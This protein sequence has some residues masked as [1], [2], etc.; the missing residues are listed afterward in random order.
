M[1]TIFLCLLLSWSVS[2]SAQTTNQLSRF[3]ITWQFD[4]NVE[5]GQFVNGDYYVVAPVT[6]TNMLPAWTG[7]DNGWEVN[8]Q[9]QL[10]Q[11]FKA[12][13]A[14]YNA[15]RRPELPFTISTNASLVKVIGGV[16]NSSY[17]ATA[18]VLTILT[19]APDNN[20]A[21]SFRPPYIGSEKPIYNVSQLKTN[22]LPTVPIV[23][24]AKTLASV[25]V[26]FSKCLRMDHHAIAPRYFRPYT[27]LV[28]YMPKNT[29]PLNESMLRLIGEGTIEDKM[30]ALILF[31]Q[32]AIDRAYIMRQG[33]GFA[34]GTGENPNQQIIAAWGAVMLGMTNYLEHYQTT[35]I[36]VYEDAMISRN[37]SD[38]VL[39]GEQPSSSWENFYWTYIRTGSGNKKIRDPYGFIDGGIPGG[40]G[41]Q[42]IVSQPFKAQ[43]LLLTLFPEL[44]TGFR[45]ETVTNILDYSRRWVTNGYWSLPDPVAPY[46]GISTNYTITYGPDGMGGYIA[47]PSRYPT[48]HG[49]TPDGGQY[50][51]TWIASMWVEHIDA[52]TPDPGPE[53][54]PPFNVRRIIAGTANIGSINKRP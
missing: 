11:G 47:G 4:S 36:K 20:G 48:R 16:F 7:T 12:S 2:L 51:S 46:D 53:P 9:V 31:T 44:K 41:Y 39:W 38:I 40:S 26:D 19:N 21:D 50:R 27:S 23:G 13:F 29:I 34:H 25:V 6:V 18:A 33:Y 5:Y 42:H 30:P 43:A 28:D 3:G 8:P 10:D 54:D 49:L 15:A 52:E 37:A 14:Y 32:H 24:T 45:P 22:L 1:R 35:D 17:I